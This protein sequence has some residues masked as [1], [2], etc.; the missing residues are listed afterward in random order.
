MCR[1]YSLNLS[2]PPLPL[3]STCPLNSDFWPTLL[4]L[5]Y[6]SKYR[7]QAK[8]Q[9]NH[10]ILIPSFSKGLESQLPI[11][12]FPNKAFFFFFSIQFIQLYSCLWWESKSGTSYS[13]MAR[14]KICY[15]CFNS[16]WGPLRILPMNF[17]VSKLQVMTCGFSS[18]WMKKIYYPVFQA[19]PPWGYSSPLLHTALFR[20][21]SLCSAHT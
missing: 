20:R 5:D 8:S 14:S 21:R 17:G 11:I 7:T 9:D 18:D 16:L 19:S 13:I 4:A 15:T 12:Q 10:G 6:F 1:S 2:C 3:L